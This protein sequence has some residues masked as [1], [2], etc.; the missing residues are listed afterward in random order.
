MIQPCA[1]VT[2]AGLGGDSGKTLVALG[3]AAGWAEKGL[4]V[5]PFKK[6][7]DYIDAAWLSLAAGAPCRNL[8]TFLMPEAA[9]LRTWEYCCQRS[10]VAVVEGNRGLFDGLD[11]HGSHST[12]QLAKHLQSPVILVVDATK[13]TATLAAIVLGVRQFDPSLDLAGVVLNRI[14]GSRHEKVAREAIET[15]TDVKVLGAIPRVKGG[16]DLLPG[17]HLGLITVEEHPRAIAAI[18]QA[19]SLVLDHVDVTALTATQQRAGSPLN[20]CI[21]PHT[22]MSSI[23]DPPSASQTLLV[24]D[25]LASPAPIQVY[26]GT[27]QG[28][29]TPGPVRIAVIRDSAFSFYYPENLEALKRGGADIVT[30]DSLSDKTLP[31]NID[32]LYIGGGFPETHAKKIADNTE[33]LKSIKLA[34][35]S[36]LPI[37]AECGGLMLLCE[38]I[39]FDGLISQMAGVF[40]H[41]VSWSRK[42]AGHGYTMGV[43]RELNPFYPIGTKI[44]GHEFHHSHFQGLG[45]DSGRATVMRLSKGNG[46]GGGHD[47]LSYKNVL[48]L[49]THVHAAGTTEWADGMLSAA[50]RYKEGTTLPR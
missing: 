18:E 11:A 37:Y 36:G 39:E 20:I 22:D 49:Y 6:G 45:G 32:A 33:L 40:P 50:W 43:I 27:A 42:P 19:R 3:L 28:K 14:G 5:A 2:V 44:R 35:E 9:I 48:A 46:V 12:A 23:P 17:R 21:L 34:A 10:D 30:V 1:S 16:E 4:R 13:V 8:D 25:R 31:E 29:S 24:E 38:S 15:Y 26:T 7:P 47:G 41:R